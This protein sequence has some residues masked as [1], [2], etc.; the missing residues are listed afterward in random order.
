MEE[1][2][3]EN[4]KLKE[5]INFLESII[6]RGNTGT[7]SVYNAIRLMIMEKVKKEVEILDNVEEWK[8]KDTIQKAE[9]HI[10]RDLKWDLHVRTIRRF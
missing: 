2:I 5:R 1:L 7:S 8:N 3:E 10:M 4:N 6:N 9:R